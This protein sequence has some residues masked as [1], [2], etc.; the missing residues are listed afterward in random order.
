[1]TQAL[2]LKLQIL[3]PHPMEVLWTEIESD[4]VFGT[5][6]NYSVD[7]KFLSL[8]GAVVGPKK[9]PFTSIRHNS[10]GHTN[11][12]KEQNPPSP[13]YFLPY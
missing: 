5:D 8:I 1:M 7:T 12:F 4:L 9:S 6:F 3:A 2:I 13:H 11:D 10:V